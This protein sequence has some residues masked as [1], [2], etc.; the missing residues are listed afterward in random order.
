MARDPPG[1]LQPRP[2]HLAHQA[3]I[4]DRNRRRAV[5]R[6]NPDPP[7]A[8]DIDAGFN[9]AAPSWHYGADPARIV[10]QRDELRRVWQALTPAL[11]DAVQLYLATDGAGAPGH[12]TLAF[13]RARKRAQATLAA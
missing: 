9:I 8:L 3:L 10:I 12:S 7:V 6:W 13:Y 2:R 5:K 11:R 1:P 4:D